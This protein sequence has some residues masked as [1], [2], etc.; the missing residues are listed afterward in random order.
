MFRLGFGNTKTI[1]DDDFKAGTVITPQDSTSQINDQ[2]PPMPPNPDRRP[3]P[4]RPPLA[5]LADDPF[6]ADPPSLRP[7]FKSGSG[8][9]GGGKGKKVLLVVIFLV[10][11]AAVAYGVYYWQHQRVNKLASQNDGYSQQIADLQKQVSQLKAD[12]SK[13][14]PPANQ[15]IIKVKELGIQLTV[16]DSLKDLT[17]V[18]KT[19]SS[20]GKITI[21][22]TFT[23]RSLLTKDTNCTAAR[24][25]IG[26][27][28]K[29][30]G[31]YPTNPTE[32]DGT[33][34][35]QF[36]NF[37]VS[38]S[39]SQSS[40]SAEGN[41]TANLLQTGQSADLQLAASSVTEIK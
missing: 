37:Y 16:P 14:A 7:Q 26:T 17:Y 1:M 40:C 10:V 25:P 28:S 6:K 39:H 18:T 8:Q 19:G 22:A 11:L 41:T 15:N 32:S 9:T 13:K 24:G 23:T 34:I 4:P 5:P 29:V 38:Y 3:T 27:I 21:A 33:L 20:D 31:T 2:R 30:T 12:N 35:K 36:S